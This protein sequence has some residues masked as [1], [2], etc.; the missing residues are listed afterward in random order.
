MEVEHVGIVDEDCSTSVRIVDPAGQL[1]SKDTGA[2]L[3]RLTRVRPIRC[4]QQAF[5]DA[6]DERQDEGPKIT[7]IDCRVSDG[8]D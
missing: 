2:R 3:H 1:G 8:I 7:V 5:R 6:I 4:P